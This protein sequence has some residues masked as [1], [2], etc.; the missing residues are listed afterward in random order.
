MGVIGITEN[1]TEANDESGG[2][3]GGS[4][5][6][7][8]IVGVM[9]GLGGATAIGLYCFKR[10][11]EAENN[12]KAAAP[13]RKEMKS[14]KSLSFSRDVAPAAPVTSVK[15]V[16][17]MEWSVETDPETGEVYYFNSETGESTWDDP[18]QKPKPAAPPPLP[19]RNRVN[20]TVQV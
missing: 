3:G 20:P 16:V 2:G 1:P 18:R 8:A 11:R 17:T 12:Q 10:R 13:R 7:G 4:V 19:S 15:R 6:A 9:F 5:D 14:F